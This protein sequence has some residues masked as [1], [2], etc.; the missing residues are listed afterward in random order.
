MPRVLDKVDLLAAARALGVAWVPDTVAA[1][2][3][4]HVQVLRVEEAFEWH[5]HRHTDDLFLALDEQVHIDLRER[6]VTL[7]RGE[8]FV[9]PANVEHRLR[10]DVPAH[11]LC[12]EHLGDSGPVADARVL[13]AEEPARPG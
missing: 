12:I 11:V 3:G 1:F 2:N 10:A 4:H 5:H 7:A 9:V 6:T 13:E 8:L